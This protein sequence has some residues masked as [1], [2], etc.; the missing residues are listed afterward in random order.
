MNQ[1]QTVRPKFAYHVR[2]RHVMEMM[3]KLSFF[4]V[5]LWFYN[6]VLKAQTCTTLGQNPSTAFPVCGTTAFSQSTVPL[7][8]NRPIPGPCA[9]D[10]VTDKNPFWYRFTCYTPGTLGFVINPNNNSDDYDWQLFDITNRNPNDVFTDASLF[11]ACNWSG[12][13]GNTGASSSGRSL[14]V[15][16]GFGKPLYS[17]MPLLQQGRNYLLLIS[18]FTNSQSGYSL[19]FTGG[20]AGI[21]DPNLP[22]MLYARSNCAGNQL[23]LKLNKKLKCNSISA[24]GSEF[25]IPGASA[26]AIT[27]AGYDCGSSFDT[28]SLTINL[29]Q[30]LSPGTYQLTMRNGSDGNT[31]KDNCDRSI[32]VGAV[33]P[34]VI[35]PFAPT[36]MDS[37]SP[38]GCAPAVLRLVF[39]R[40]IQCS[41]IAADGSD[42]F[43]TGSS[44][45]TVASANGVCNTDGLS[46]IIEVKLGAPI[47]LQG[48]YQIHLKRG[49]DGNTIIDECNRE[50][51]PGAMLPFNTADTVSADFTYNIY[52]GCKY[53]TV[54]FFHD[55]AHQVNSWFWVF[56]RNGFSSLQQPRSIFSQFGY[57]RISLVTSNG[58]CSDTVTKVINLDNVL[59][60][61]FVSPDIVC[62]QEMIQFIDTSIGHIALWEWRFGNGNNSSLK[63]PPPQNYTAPYYSNEQKYRVWLTVT[64]SLGCQD[65]VFSDITAVGNCYISVPSAFTPNGDGVNDYLFAM[66]A[67]KAVNLD[68]KIF[69]RWGQL[70]FQTTDFRKKWDGTFRGQIQQTDTY[71]WY[72]NYTHRETKKRFNLKGTTVLIR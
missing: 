46:S 38:V 56:D 26:V 11:V 58:V 66:N 63:Q 9:S 1:F 69:N 10:I 12:D 53:D 34:L 71:V 40:D 30:S 67:Y 24:D 65:A 3:K 50:T 32:P 54:T 64:D 51:P 62:P 16:A 15:C 20:T 44:P 52:Y 7:C 5:L 49:T 37:L 57:K 23:K 29:N 61:G 72:L 13:G 2:G 60:A 59:K 17:S 27:T 19:E 55:G 36:P 39:K 6:P 25:F 21:T 31:L 47:Y 35:L 43:V 28:D 48:N 33:V 68:F 42:F 70:L 45:I 8:G 18:H 4:L 22:A 14:V 41:S